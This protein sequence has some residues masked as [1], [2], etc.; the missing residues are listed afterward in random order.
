MEEKKSPREVLNKFS[1]IEKLGKFKNHPDFRQLTR[2]GDKSFLRFKKGVYIIP[3][4]GSYIRYIS[5]Q[6]YNEETLKEVFTITP[7]KCVCTAQELHPF[8]ECICNS[9]P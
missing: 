2:I 7:K 4:D 5:N 9:K 6:W 1:L 3:D 8:G